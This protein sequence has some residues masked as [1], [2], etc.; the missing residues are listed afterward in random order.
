METGEFKELVTRE[1]DILFA[2]E[3]EIMSLYEV[4]TFDEAL[5]AVRAQV[6]F[7]A[8]TRGAKGSVVVKGDEVHVIDAATPEVQPIGLAR[9]QDLTETIGLAQRIATL[10]QTHQRCGI[11]AV[12]AMDVAMLGR[13]HPRQFAAFGGSAQTIA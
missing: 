6:G 7:A 2:N 10:Q 3:S 1:V 9:L 12:T 11:K 4:Q 5:Q 13:H 8:L